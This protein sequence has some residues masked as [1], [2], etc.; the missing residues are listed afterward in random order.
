MKLLTVFLLILSSMHMIAHAQVSIMSYNIRY[1]NPDD[2]DNWWENRKQDVVDLM[3]R[4]H[5][6]FIGIQ[7]GLDHQVRFLN[8][9]LRDY[10]FVGIGRDGNG[11]ISE[12]TAIYYDTTR[13]Q[14]V[15]TKTFWLSPTPNEVSKGWDAALNR[16]ATYASFKEKSSDAMLH[17][18]NAHFDHIGNEAREKSAELILK[19]I[20]D[21]QLLDQPIVVMG[22]F[23]STPESKAITTFNRTLKDTRT[24]LSQNP[25]GPEG[26]FTGFARDAELLRRID[27]IFTKNMTVLNQRHIDDLRPNL[28]WPS[29]HLAVF[30]VLK[31]L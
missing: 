16:I 21:W 18:F 2:G 11:V 4:Y 17:L 29:D 24:M 1:S 9:S 12:Y 8:E 7:E 13:Y 27:Y 3:D 31:F 6:D 5:P 23:N 15:E 14:L 10:K 26:T 30:A 19:Q 20:T 28:L 22:D 25:G